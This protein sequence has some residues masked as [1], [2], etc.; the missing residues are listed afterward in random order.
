M[1]VP[2]L[3]ID[4]ESAV[5]VYRQIADGVRESALEG[6]MEAGGK[7]PPT[8]EL[9]RQ[10]GVNRQTVVAAYEY[11]ANR[12]WVRSHTGK[13]TFL[14]V[15]S[16]ATEP[17]TTAQ[18]TTRH[19]WMPTFS[20]AVE[21]P[22]VGGLLSFYQTATTEGGIS[23]AGSYPAR[24]LMPVEA[25]GRALDEAQREEGADLLIY[26]P[27]TGHLG[28]RETIAAR[29]RAAGSQ[30]RADELLITNGAQQAIELV[31]HTFLERGDPV[32]IEEP[33]YTGALSVLAS[34]GARVI[35][36]QVD[37]Q[38]MRPDSLALALDRYRPR[39][40]YV[41]PSFQNPTC[42]VMGE[43]RRRELL[44]L[45]ARSRCM[46]LED[47]WASGMSFGDAEPPT[48]HALDGGGHVI[49]LSTFSKKLMPGLRVGWCSAPGP[50]MKRLVAL[51]QIR[52]CGTSPL[53]QA[54]LH[55]FLAADGLEQHLGRVLPVYRERRDCMLSAL[56]RHFPREASW[57][58]PNGGLFVWVTLPSGCDAKELFATAARRDVMVS[59][60]DVFHS[61]SEGGH[62][63]RLT[64]SAATPAEIEKGIALLG[65]LIH[66]QGSQRSETMVGRSAEPVPIL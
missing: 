1:I 39:L 13:G 34:I 53:L 59:S 37:D 17:D 40:M 11:L 61:N 56:E 21:G 50:I 29:M 44:A 49:Y 3:E 52:D 57:T 60:G 27:T 41:Q 4:H 19:S 35:G 25:F 36:V 26:G 5:P 54:A 20:R 6:R 47:D 24:E 15:P 22:N 65:N 31:F 63:L 9:A 12:G 30:V 23:F 55:K 8:R 46:V 42:A 43:A 38:G 33:T 14:A 7:L 51:K 16:K 10:L 32:L 48:L 62:T 64:Y 2:G 45:A 18:R 58:R 28:L 66:T